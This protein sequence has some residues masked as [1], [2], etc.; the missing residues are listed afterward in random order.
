[1]SAP[2]QARANSSNVATGSGVI[3]VGDNSYIAAAPAGT[4]S[5]YVP[6]TQFTNSRPLRFR[7]TEAKPNSP[8]NNYGYGVLAS[9]NDFR[10]AL[11]QVANNLQIP[12]QWLADVI[13]HESLDTMRPDERNGLATG[14]IQFMPETAR[15][16]GTTTEA[17]SRMTRAQQMNYVYRHLSP[18]KGRIESIFDIAVAVFRPGHFDKWKRGEDFEGKQHLEQQYFPALGKFV[19]RS[20][21]RSQ[22]SVTHT[23][24]VAS[25]TLCQRAQ[26]GG[27]VLPHEVSAYG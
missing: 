25:C 14:L 27:Y 3:P 5:T 1:M 16:Y 22:A 19:G 26:A 9:D 8:S 2:P 24:F 18:F 4:G 15:E 11:D 20:Y 23:R 6:P 13:A 12:G 7:D 10:L 21:Y 17:L